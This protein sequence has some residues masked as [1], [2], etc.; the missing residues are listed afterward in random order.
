MSLIDER[1]ESFQSLILSDYGRFRLAHSGDV[2]IYENLDV[3]PRAFLVNRATV[4]ADGEEALALMQSDAFYPT[5][6]VVLEQPSQLPAGEDSPASSTVRVTHYAPEMVTVEVDTDA[7]GYL[8]LTDAW[9]PG[10]EASIDDEP[11]AIQRADLLF[12]AVAVGAGSHRV[13]FS[14]RP[15]SLRI[16]AIASLAGLIGLAAVSATGVPRRLIVQRRARCYNGYTAVRHRG[17]EDEI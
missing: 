2:K 8:V 11:V 17:K 16:G 13:V 1:T 6:Q 14:L 3:L 5:A 12:R 9:Y 4:A 7:P 15:L 10:W